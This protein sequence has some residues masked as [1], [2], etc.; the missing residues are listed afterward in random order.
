MNEP[1]HESAGK[2]PP[3]S[4][5]RILNTRPSQVPIGNMHETEAKHHYR[6][7][8]N[9]Q[10]DG[11]VALHIDRDRSAHCIT[12][13]RKGGVYAIRRDRIHGH[14]DG[15]EIGLL[16]SQAPCTSPAFSFSEAYFTGNA[17]SQRFFFGETDRSSP[18]NADSP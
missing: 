4:T 3:A 12:A 5:R 11:S 15:F 1:S 8:D 9:G 13:Q 17:K 16:L 7:E 10:I 14:S 18:A 2:Q 6:R